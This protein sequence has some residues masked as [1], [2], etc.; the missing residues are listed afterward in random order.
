MPEAGNED[1]EWPV[2]RLH[3]NSCCLGTA[4]MKGCGTPTMWALY[5]AT[6]NSLSSFLAEDAFLWTGDCLW[7]LAL[8]PH[9]GLAGLRDWRRA[10]YSRE[11]TTTFSLSRR[12]GLPV[13]VY[14]KVIIHKFKVTLPDE[15]CTLNIYQL[16]THKACDPKMLATGDLGLN[17]PTM[18]LQ[19]NR[20]AFQHLAIKLLED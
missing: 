13:L 7:A 20:E 3:H 4:D 6:C 2:I 15:K 5:T 19:G 8:T 16:N 14:D 9:K 1:N 10:I 18:L 17:Q 12:R 11:S